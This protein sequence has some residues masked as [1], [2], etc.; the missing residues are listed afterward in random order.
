M[1]PVMVVPE[2]IGSPNEKILHLDRVLAVQI[3]KYTSLQ[4]KFDDLQNHFDERL[5]SQVSKINN[6]VTR[7]NEIL[8]KEVSSFVK[9][10]I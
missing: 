5:S 8:K 7:N 1:S 4:H 2:P 9:I 6:G 3:E 10:C